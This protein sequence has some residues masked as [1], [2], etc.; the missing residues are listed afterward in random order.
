MDLG[1]KNR[2]ALVTAASKGLGRATALLLAQEGARVAI[3]ARA[4][5]TQGQ[6]A[7]NR[8]RDEIAAL[9]GDVLALQADVSEPGAAQTLIDATLARFGG[10]DVLIANA[11]GPPAG[12]FQNLSEKDWEAAVQLTLMS[13]VRLCKAAI[14]VMIKSAAASI[15]AV[16]SMSVKQPLDNLILS[17][18]LRLGVTGIVKSLADELGPDGVRVNAICPGW[19]HTDRVDHLLQD[20]AARNGTSVDAEVAPIARAVPLGR[21]AS[22]DEFAR[23]AAFLVSPAASY[24]TGVSL[25][26]DGG[27][28]RGVM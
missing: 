16:T 11:G 22:P 25:L 5:G 26:V 28:Y 10:L 1:L 3:C 14:P 21:L 24:I 17:N 6:A 9:G 15:L 7:L 18:S 12:G 23:A 8:T 2:V 20:R 13:F 27:M 4:R 19:T